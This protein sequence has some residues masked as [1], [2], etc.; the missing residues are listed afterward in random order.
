MKNHHYIISPILLGTMFLLSEGCTLKELNEEAHTTI[1]DKVEIVFDWS[2]VMNPQAKTMGL[3][4]FSEDHDMM[5]YWFNNPN[6]GT[7]RTYGGR[8]TM[9]CHSN[10]DPYGH[11][12]RNQHAHEE[13]EIF[14]GDTEMLL[15]QG[16]STRGIPR[17]PGTEQE[18]LR[19]TPSMIYGTHDKDIR[20]Q[21]S[22]LPQTVTLY[23][24]EFVCHYSVEFVNVKNIKSATVNIDATISSLA[25]GYYPGKMAQS[26]ESVSHPFTLTADLE[27]NSL[28]SEFYTFGVPAGAAKPHM[29]CVYVA[30]KNR[31]GN[32]Y[33]FDV[34]DQVNNA[35]DPRH[36][37]IQIAGL[38]LP[39]IPDD[40]PTP[41]AQGGVSIEIDSWDTYYF[42]LQV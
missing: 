15:G 18:P 22:S 34:S 25:G 20:L 3:Y 24:E 35:E 38:E 4:I 28:Y 26:S 19:S 7:I 10:D 16:I 8:H 23:P 9:I 12:I 11:H 37:R 40:P 36:V 27:N 33:T 2:K 32:S 13:M 41:P 31:N 39:E 29:I 42:G 21:I 5:D 1:A 30:L 14:T 6:G 17:A